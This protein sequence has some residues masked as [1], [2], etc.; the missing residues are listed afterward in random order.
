MI[1]NRN[2]LRPYA[3]IL[4]VGLFFS[5]DRSRGA[6]HE[7]VA[8]STAGVGL[9]R[10]SEH[11]TMINTGFEEAVP[12]SRR[13]GASCISKPTAPVAGPHQLR[14]LGRPTGER[15]PRM[16]LAGELGP[17]VKTDGCEN[18][19]SLSR[20]EHHLFFSR[21]P[22]D[23]WVSYRRD[24]RDPFGWEPESVSVRRS[25]GTLPPR[26]PPGSSSAK[27]MGSRNCTS[28]AP[29]LADWAWPTFMSPSL[30]IGARRARAQQS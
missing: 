16:G 25:T 19:V 4:A 11:R 10:A 24:V 14:H 2:G 22:G 26:A 13:T 20:D 17:A 7:V 30:R 29:D 5:I 21:P 23:I 27:S 9:V 15:P 12:P 18:S 1:A 8:R 28:S 6:N 3:S